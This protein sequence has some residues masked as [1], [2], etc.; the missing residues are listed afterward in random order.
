MQENQEK[1]LVSS[2]HRWANNLLVTINFRL[3]RLW[4]LFLFGLT[5]VC[6]FF[7]KWM[8]YAYEKVPYLVEEKSRGLN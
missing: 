1:L 3:I 6:K 8:I 5:V 2:H 4:S 7:Y